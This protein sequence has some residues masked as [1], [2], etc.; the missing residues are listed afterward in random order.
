MVQ[1][2]PGL[3][4]GL[5]P[6]AIP[7]PSPPSRVPPRLGA[8]VGVLALGDDVQCPELLQ[9]R[10]GGLH[11]ARVHRGGERDRDSAVGGRT[12]GGGWM[13]GEVEWEGGA[14]EEIWKYAK[15]GKK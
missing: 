9:P 14:E 3:T 13:R 7:P 10:H 2:N 4:P 6:L 8:A 12:Q 15:G 5:T 1:R 11:G